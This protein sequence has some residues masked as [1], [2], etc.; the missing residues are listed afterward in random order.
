MLTLNLT[1]SILI[2]DSLITATISKLLFKKVMVIPNLVNT[3]NVFYDIFHGVL[4]KKNELPV[5]GLSL[6]RVKILKIIASPKRELPNG[7][8][9][10]YD[11]PNLKPETH[12]KGK[13]P[14]RV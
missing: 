12:F 7:I 5:M 6:L 3:V 8:F 10:S 4:G 1:F 13:T 2:I 9:S 11:M 14:D